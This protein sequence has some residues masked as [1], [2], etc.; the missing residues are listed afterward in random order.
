MWVCA[1]QGVL[2]KLTCHYLWHMAFA[3][4]IPNTF[5]LS[6]LHDSLTGGLGS[7]ADC[8]SSGGELASANRLA[9]QRA[10]RMRPRTTIPA[11]QRKEIQKFVVF[12][13]FVP[14]SGGFALNWLLKCNN[15]N[16]VY[17]VSQ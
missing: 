4:W 12:R 11:V 17:R 9:R 8:L 7:S 5:E 16:D 1:R 15:G 2:A 13:L 6:Y 14:T 10:R 3:A